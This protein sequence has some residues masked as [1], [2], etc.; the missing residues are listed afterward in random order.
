[1]S[2]DTPSP[3]R[4]PL[5]PRLLGRFWRRPPADLPQQPRRLAVVYLTPY[6]FFLYILA[7]LDRVNVSVARLGMAKSASEGGLG[8]TTTILG[9]G[10]GIFFWGYWILEI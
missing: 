5:A 3:P 8:I 2:A 10:A 9:F 6:L 4:R 1:M 7:D